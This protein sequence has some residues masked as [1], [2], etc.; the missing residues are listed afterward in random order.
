MKENIYASPE[1]G[2]VSSKKRSLLRRWL[3]GDIKLWK[4]IVLLQIIG[5]LVLLIST[6]MLMLALPLTVG[7]ALKAILLPS[8][9][10]Y[11]SICV[12]RAS[13]NAKASIKGA[14]AKF[15]AVLFILYGCSV[16][17]YSVT[18]LLSEAN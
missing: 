8:F 6:T 16:A 17:Y 12:F 10:I 4:A 5:W 3:E 9:A 18:T 13:P 11:S 7:I 14:I 15:W 2:L 1:A